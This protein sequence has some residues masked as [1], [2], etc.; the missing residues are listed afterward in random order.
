MELTITHQ[1]GTQVALI[2]C[3]GQPSRMSDLQSLLFKDEEELLNDP[4]AYGKA[5]YQA[6]FPPETPTQRAL[7]SAP[8]RILLI[9]TDTDL[10]AVPWEYAYGPNNFLVLECQ[11][12]RS[13]PAD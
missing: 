6:L 8:E 1:V 10:E 2:S 3:D 12:V 5:A 9:T 13:L 11:L 7:A 4:V